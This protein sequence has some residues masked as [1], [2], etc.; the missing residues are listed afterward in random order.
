M[1]SQCN[2]G[3]LKGRQGLVRH[4]GLQICQD[5]LLQPAAQVTSAC[6]AS[7]H[8]MESF[9]SRSIRICLL[10]QACR[11][12]KVCCSAIEVASTLIVILTPEL[13]TPETGLKLLQNAAQASSLLGSHLALP[14][15]LL[16]QLRY[17]AGWPG[18]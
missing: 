7:A 16:P 1:A 13:G 5:L 9:S 14:Q 11:P 12:V 2:L 8:L 18:A 10:M 3:Y 17:T 4:T 6:S 15:A